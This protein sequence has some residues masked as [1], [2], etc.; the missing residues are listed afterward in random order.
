MQCTYNNWS[1]AADLSPRWLWCVAN[2]GRRTSTRNPNMIQSFP[3]YDI[4]GN[5]YE[6]GLS[7]GEQAAE[8]VA[9]TLEIYL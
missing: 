1:N 3:V 8:R 2:G 9:R 7:H 5:A 6:C 4:E